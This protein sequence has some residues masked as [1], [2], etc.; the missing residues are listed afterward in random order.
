M[1]VVPVAIKYLLSAA[2]VGLVI[3]DQT[4]KTLKS[5]DTFVTILFV[6]IV[7]HNLK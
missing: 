6:H 5:V 4:V 2:I 7:S 1:L 3:Q